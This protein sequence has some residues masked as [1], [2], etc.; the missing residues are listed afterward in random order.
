MNW[1]GMDIGGANIKLADGTGFAAS[2]PFAMW[3]DHRKLGAELRQLIAEAP[4]C[5][6]LAVTMTGELADCFESRDE[7]VKYIVAAVQAAADRRH[8]R[9]YLSNGMLVTPQVALNKAS[10]A[11]ASNWHA[12][13]RFAGRHAKK[14]PALLIDVGSTTVDIVPLVDG[15]PQSRGFSDLDRLLCGEMVYTGVER[16]PL[17]GVILRAPYRNQQCPVAQELF[18]TTKDVYLTL[19][20]LAADEKNLATADNRPSTKDHARK[21]LGRSICADPTQFDEHDAVVMAQAAAAAQANSIAL[22]V[23][24]VSG[25]MDSPPTTILLAGHGEFL[26]RRVLDALGMQ[27]RTVSLAHEHGPAVSRCGPAHALAVLARE[28]SGL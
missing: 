14:G 1:L 24:Q 7:G 16:S 17:C 12:L 27:V 13:A 22:A 25:R 5:D 26:A 21:R 20:D 19:G 2:I 3:K 28:A 18:A 23:R 4:S 8:T 11:A 10:L 15:G 9:V 6:H